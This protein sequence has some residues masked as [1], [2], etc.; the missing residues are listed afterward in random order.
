MGE[1]EGN[2]GKTDMKNVKLNE[3]RGWS[4][5]IQKHR[6]QMIKETRG[7]KVQNGEGVPNSMVKE[8]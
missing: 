3:S 8:S 2:Q 5:Q 1:E 4:S 6:P 7:E